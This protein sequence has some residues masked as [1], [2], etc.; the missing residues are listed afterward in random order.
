MTRRLL[1]SVAVLLTAI[2]TALAQAAPPAGGSSPRHPEE[3]RPFVR[4]YAP[5]ELG[6]AS[7]NWAIVQDRRG[8]IASIDAFAGGA[9]QFDDITLMIVRRT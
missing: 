2:G 4:N 5:D 7:Q 3:G 8:V 9:P 1:L 6:G